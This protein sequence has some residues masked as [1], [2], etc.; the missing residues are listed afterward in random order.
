MRSM[1]RGMLYPCAAEAAGV[2]Q[3]TSERCHEVR[4]GGFEEVS[5]QAGGFPARAGGFFSRGA[6][7]WG[8]VR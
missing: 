7:A 8:W 4:G 6:D 2:D 5:G 1:A 3:P